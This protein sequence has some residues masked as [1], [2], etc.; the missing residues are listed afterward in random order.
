MKK[1]IITLVLALVMI[2][3]GSLVGC[4]SAPKD[5]TSENSPTATQAENTG[6]PEPTKIRIGISA[7]QDTLLPIIGQ[8]KGWYKEAGLEVEFVDL[9]WNAI[10]PAIASNSIDVAV[11]N[12]TGVVEVNGTMEDTVYLYP[13][14]IFTNGN[15]IIGREGKAKSVQD[16]EKE[17]KSHEEAVKAAIGQLKGAKVI[18]TSNTDMGKAV[19]QAAKANGLSTSDYTVID[20]DTDQG[21]AAFISGTG[22]FYS[23]GIPQ[24]NRLSSEKGFIVVATGPDLTHVPM[25]GWVTT[26]KYW[27]EHQDALLALQNVMFRIIRYTNDNIDEAGQMIIDKLNQSTGSNMTLDNFKYYW[28]N[29]EDYPANAS[30]V[31]KDILSKDGFA[32][33]G[34]TWDDDVAYCMSAGKIKKEIKYGTTTA[35][36]ADKFQELYIAKY[37]AD[38][39]GY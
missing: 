39:S 22:D 18:T 34:L 15:A 14:N 36:L 38:E 8:E 6:T 20:M 37:G 11:Y 5:T 7:Y 31:A 28:E 13:W 27:T 25:N 2:L 1:K 4:S 17:G 12:T 21:L 26:N 32:Y 10:M 19:D 23:G 16:F 30:E 29:I 9:A 24:R 3:S 33:L 35:C